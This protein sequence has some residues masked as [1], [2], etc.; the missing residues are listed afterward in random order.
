MNQRPLVAT[1]R[2]LLT[3]LALLA[4]LVPPSGA[5]WSI[6]A[7][8][9]RTGEVAVASATCLGNFD[10]KDFVPAIVV[11][12]GAA[13]A[14]SSVDLAARSRRIM[15]R[16]LEKGTT[17]DE[18]LTLLA[19]LSGH[20]SKQYG[21]V[22]MNG[23]PVTFTGTG[24]GRAKGGVVGDDGEIAYAIQ[25][26][27]LAGE[28]VFLVAESAFLDRPGDLGQRIMA[29]MEAARALGGDGRCSCSGTQ[30]TSCGTPPPG[31]TKSAH[32]GFILLARMG[33]IDGGC[34]SFTGC[35]A[36]SYYLDL[37]VVG[38]PNDPD[39]VLQ[40]QELYGDWRRERVGRPDH[41]LSSAATDFPS[42]PADGV[43]KTR[44]LVRLADLKGV[45]LTRGGAQI[46][47]TPLDAQA[48]A[49]TIGPVDD[50]DNGTYLFEITAS[51]TPGEGSFEIKA[52]D[53]V[54]TATLFP[55][56][57]V[58]LDPPSGLHVGGGLRAAAPAGGSATAAPFVVHAPEV[59]GS[60]FALVAWLAPSGAPL[61]PRSLALAVPAG[62]APW[63][64]SAGRLDAAG[65]AAG[66]FALPPAL[67]AGTLSASGWELWLQAIHAAG[68]TAPVALMPA[69]LP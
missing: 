11:G 32:V 64:G 48:S 52:D 66:T 42:I 58:R 10:L 29:S 53:G 12:K 16:E 68:A 25:G 21:I 59:P 27:V 18:I 31:F 43:T 67:A 62:T 15:Y 65:R 7:V 36:G 19:G 13:A 3:P 69:R 60:P 35:A 50:N 47:V 54:V 8:N 45:P 26:N 40:L 14:Q 63:I 61:A 37:N 41:L 55:Y 28:E 57:T 49:M 34:S 56:L 24:A 6:V 17:P 30:P 38:A 4:L 22:G 20:Q 2:R 33:D 46:T 9:R 44:V 1:T 39:P 51:T 23:A 5:T